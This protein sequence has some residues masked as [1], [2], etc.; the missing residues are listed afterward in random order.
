M[1]S[2]CGG[3]ARA[4]L[5]RGELLLVV[6]DHVTV[7]VGTAGWWH[8]FSGLPRRLRSAQ[9]MV[10]GSGGGGAAPGLICQDLE[11]G[12]RQAARGVGSDPAWLSCWVWSVMARWRPLAACMAWRLC[13]GPLRLGPSLRESGV[14]EAPGRRWRAS[15][16]FS[17]HG[18]AVGGAGRRSSARM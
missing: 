10:G 11:V 3:A 12:R 13:C 9:V 8:L 6:R 2:R 7:A 14:G 15:R 18:D 17:R 16:S 1:T 5:H 4:R